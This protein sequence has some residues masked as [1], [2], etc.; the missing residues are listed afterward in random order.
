MSLQKD[1]P[2]HSIRRFDLSDFSTEEA[3][4]LREISALLQK[5][6]SLPVLIDENG[7]RLKLPRLIQDFLRRAVSIL[8]SGKAISLIPET[9][10]LT[11]QAA[12]DLLGFSRPHLIELLES[13]KIPFYKVGS[14][15]RIRLQDVL[16]SQRNR[17]QK[18]KEALDKL[19][20]KIDEAGFY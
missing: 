14:H 19:S 7:N 12:A 18:R 5:N 3:E 2:I 6:Q 17:D 10:S 11:T 4:S 8:E 15:R 1:R 13:G 20:R 9:E 16:N